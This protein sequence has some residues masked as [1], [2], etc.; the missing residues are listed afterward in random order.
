MADRVIFVCTLLLAGVYLYATEQ[1]PTLEI[2]DPL[3]PKAFPRLLGAGLLLAAVLLF[4]EIVKDRKAVAAN[5][6]RANA[7]ANRGNSTW[8]VAAVAVWTLLYFLVF[9]R[10]GYVV[11]TTLYLIPLMAYFNKGKWTANVVTAVLF[12]II[13]YFLFGK[14]LSVNVARGVLPF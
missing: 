4:F 14:V 10:L 12:C 6:P 7:A 9:E 8:V 13:S 5:A 2:G 3:G 11:A 1:L